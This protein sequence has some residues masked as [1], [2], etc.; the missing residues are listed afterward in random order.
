MERKFDSNVPNLY[1]FLNSRSG[2]CIRLQ[3]FHGAG[4]EGRD[5]RCSWLVKRA[6]AL[7]ETLSG[8][9]FC[10]VARKTVCFHLKGGL[11]TIFPVARG[12]RVPGNFSLG[13]SPNAASGRRRPLHKITLLLV[14]PLRWLRC[15]FFEAVF[16]RDIC[17][18]GSRPLRSSRPVPS[19]LFP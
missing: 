7:R 1:R 8:R 9:A 18:R 5:R 19:T 14:R 12:R 11:V 15:P 17:R 13:P 10:P 16:Y 4:L 6:G 3:N 2:S